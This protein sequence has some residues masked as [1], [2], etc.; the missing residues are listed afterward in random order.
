MKVQF[1]PVEYHSMHSIV[2]RGSNGSRSVGQDLRRRNQDEEE[3]EDESSEESGRKDMTVL[4]IETL[5]M[6]RMK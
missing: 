1:N 6:L 4:I 3:D 2:D 5:K